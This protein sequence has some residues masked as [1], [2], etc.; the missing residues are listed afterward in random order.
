MAIF[1]VSF[2]SQLAIG[3][4]VPRDD[5][6]EGRAQL[7][8]PYRMEMAAVSFLHLVVELEGELYQPR[9]AGLGYLIIGAA[10]CEV[11]GFVE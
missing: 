4:S 7:S 9:I 8:S 10:G 2:L 6:L 1:A 3:K 5:K 11:I